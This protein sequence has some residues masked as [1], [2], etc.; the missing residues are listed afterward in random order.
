MEV[1]KNAWGD[2]FDYDSG[3]DLAVKSDDRTPFSGG[4]RVLV[5]DLLSRQQTWGIALGF[6]GIGLLLGAAIVFLKAPMALWIGIT[7]LFL[8]WSYHGP[9]LRLAY[10]GLGELDVVFCYG[11]LISLSTYIIQTDSF[12]LDVFWLSIPLG[13]L[14]AAFLWVN[15]FPDYD[16]DKDHG[17]HNLVVRLG[18]TRAG[19]LLPLI[20]L[21]A[22]L[23]ILIMPFISSLGNWIWLSLMF[24]PPAVLVCWWTWND[25]EYFYRNKPVQP[26]ALISFVIYSLGAGG[27]VL[28]GMSG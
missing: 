22:F 28:V 1:A 23:F 7:G 5:D 18:K 27:G 9:P 19:R 10:R 4:K 13:V 16:A 24:A 25:P 20:Y 15:E 26:L 17:K 8:G 12:S 21:T 11:P 6:G 2:V 3:T 14:I